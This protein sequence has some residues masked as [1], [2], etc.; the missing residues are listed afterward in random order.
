MVVFPEPKNPPRRI[1]GIFF[2]LVVVDDWSSVGV[3]VIR[4][5][6]AC[7]DVDVVNVRDVGDPG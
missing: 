5:R 6:V 1:V 4:R 7:S 2:F 3:G